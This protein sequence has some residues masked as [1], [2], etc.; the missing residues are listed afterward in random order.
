ME[1]ELEALAQQHG[2]EN[3]VRHNGFVAAQSAYNHHVMIY[4]GNRAISHHSVTEPMTDEEL[5]Q[6]IDLTIMP[7]ED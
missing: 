1:K 2:W 6:L 7:M 4:S 5:R 3:V